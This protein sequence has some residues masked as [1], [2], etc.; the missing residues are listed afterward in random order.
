M[1]RRIKVVRLGFVPAGI[2]H[3]VAHRPFSHN[4]HS[5]S[6]CVPVQLAHHARFKL[7][8]TPAIP[9]RS[10]VVRQ[11]TSFAKTV[12]ENFPVHFSSSNLNAGNSYPRQQR[13]WNVFRKLLS[14]INPLS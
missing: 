10:A 1:S 5:G 6:R 2:D 4:A 12:P 14:P 9:S 11:F 8:E 13:I 7:L 3:G